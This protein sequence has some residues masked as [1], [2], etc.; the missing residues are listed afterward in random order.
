MLKKICFSQ[1]QKIKTGSRLTVLKWPFLAFKAFL[2]DDTLKNVGKWKQK[3]THEHKYK[4]HMYLLFDREF[5]NSKCLK[6][7]FYDQTKKV[8]NFGYCK[9]ASKTV[10]CIRYL[11]WVIDIIMNANVSLLDKSKLKFP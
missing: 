6:R 5:K 9:N 2:V 8:I 3:R 4:L 10:I 1:E 7:Y 11:I